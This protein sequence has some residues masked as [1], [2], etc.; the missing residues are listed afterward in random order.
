M[1]EAHMSKTQMT[2]YGPNSMINNS[3]ASKWQKIL[4][5]PKSFENSWLC[6]VMNPTTL[7]VHN[8][9]INSYLKIFQGQNFDPWKY[10]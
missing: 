8:S 10:F 2:H 4:G 7:H 9:H 1:N 6:Q 5:I 3:D